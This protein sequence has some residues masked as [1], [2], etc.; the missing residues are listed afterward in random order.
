M[1]DL[2]EVWLAR[3]GETAWSR[4]GRHTGR[5]DVPLEPAGEAQ[6]RQLG[7]RLKGHA[8]AEVW[9]SPRVR[10]VRTAQLAGFAAARV[11]DDLAEWNYGEFEGLRRAEIEGFAPG[12]DVFRDGAP[13]G[14][15]A[16]EVQARADRVIARLRAGGRRARVRARALPAR[17]RARWIGLPVVFASRLPLDRVGER[18]RLR[19]RPRDP[20]RKLWNDVHHL[21]GRLRNA[22]SLPFSCSPRPRSPL[23]PTPRSRR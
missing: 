19:A 15:S 10:A 6:A 4:T 16:E 18:A 7:A 2:P 1:S 5:T 11:V 22:S 21:T 3:H 20:A 23:C 13:G 9:T 8:F 17:A 14:E 12:W